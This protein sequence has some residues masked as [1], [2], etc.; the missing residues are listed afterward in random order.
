M[1]ANNIKRFFFMLLLANTCITIFS[2]PFLWRFMD[3]D[4]LKIFGLFLYT[5]IAQIWL[6]A[7]LMLLYLLIFSNRKLW[8]LNIWVTI[9]FKLLY[10]LLAAA[11]AT[12]ILIHITYIG[13]LAH[14]AFVY[15]STGL[16]LLVSYERYLKERE[17]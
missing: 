15:I 4:I 1:D 13:S 10:T 9:L 17:A 11:L 2:L 6:V 16:I 3:G 12:K 5:I 8:S 14:N 7:L